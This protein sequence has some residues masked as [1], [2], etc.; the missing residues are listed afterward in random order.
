MMAILRALP[1]RCMRLL[2]E[3]VVTSFC[4]NR[5]NST[6]TPIKAAEPARALVTVETVE[7]VTVEIK[8]YTF[9]T[10]AIIPHKND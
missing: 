9:P 2:S 1:K 10:S 4:I 5:T 6:T 3:A 8:T 7:M